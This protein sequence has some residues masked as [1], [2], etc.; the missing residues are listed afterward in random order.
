MA[1]KLVS[2]NRAGS[3]PCICTLAQGVVDLLIADE[4]RNSTGG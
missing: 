3:M 2:E 1:L 4:A